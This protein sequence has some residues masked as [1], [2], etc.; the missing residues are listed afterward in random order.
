MNEDWLRD[1]R[2]RLL[3]APQDGA[4]IA[5][6]VRA[7]APGMLERDGAAA[8]TPAHFLVG[9]WKSSPSGLHPRLP[10][11]AAIASPDASRALRELFVHLPPDARVALVDEEYADALVLAQMV[12][13]CDRNLADWQRE[14]LEHFIARLEARRQ[15]EIRARY[16]DREADFERFRGRLLGENAAMQAAVDDR[17]RAPDGDGDPS[18]DNDNDNYN[19]RKGDP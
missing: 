2:K 13:A 15:Q 12:L 11:F 18:S 14:A 4:W 10:E 19:D 7:I 5:L 6:I 17:K 1:A 16:T 8:R 3:A 9:A